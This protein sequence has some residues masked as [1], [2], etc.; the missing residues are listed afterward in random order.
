[1]QGAA[2]GTRYSTI[3][4]DLVL[5]FSCR[6]AA[7]QAG[8]TPLTLQTAGDDA[9]PPYGEFTI[10]RLVAGSPVGT[11]ATATPPAATYTY[12]ASQREADGGGGVATVKIFGAQNF[13]TPLLVESLQAQRVDVTFTGFGFEFGDYFGGITS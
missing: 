7:L 11:M 13:P 12:S 9:A 1:M 2:Y 5:A 8:V 4:G 3:T 10:Y 6:N